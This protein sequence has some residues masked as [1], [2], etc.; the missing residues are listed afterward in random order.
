MNMP[1]RVLKVLSIKKISPLSKSICFDLRGTPFPFYAGQYIIVGI[2]LAASGHFNTRDDM[3]TFQERPFS[4]FSLP[5]E[6]DSLEII[7]VNKDNAFTSDYF[8]NYMKIGESV[9]VSG[10]FGKSFFD[11]TRSRQ[12]LMLIGAGAGTLPLITIARY[13]KAQNLSFNVHFIGSYK[14]EA[15]IVMHDVI[16]RCFDRTPHRYIV[17]L[18]KEK[19]PGYTGRIS[20]DLIA[21]ADIDF[22]KTD[23]YICGSAE[24]ISTMQKML[25]DDLHIS[26]LQIRK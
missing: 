9:T 14:K 11:P 1:T 2:D 21:K 8:L 19:W 12:N 24:F 10:P 3:A 18:T 7:V 5:S 13:V 6:K 26:P 22:K 15:G 23:F 25:T 4:I 16:E 20:K 17:T